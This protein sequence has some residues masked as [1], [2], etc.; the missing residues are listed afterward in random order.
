MKHTKFQW[1]FS[2]CHP[3]QNIDKFSEMLWSTMF[4]E[5]DRFQNLPVIVPIPTQMK[6][7]ACNF[8]KKET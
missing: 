7:L 5:T 8:I 4:P 1:E 2:E 6:P 3:E